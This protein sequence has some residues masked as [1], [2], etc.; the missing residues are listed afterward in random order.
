MRAGAAQIDRSQA[1]IVAQEFID[2]E[3]TAS[4]D[5]APAPYYIFSRGAGKGFVIV[6]GDDAIAP[7][8]GYTDQGDYDES[9]LPIQLKTYLKAWEEKITKLQQQNAG[10]K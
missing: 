3:D 10:V 2:I 8:L 7:I 5:V 1:R 9:Q 4:D 6:S